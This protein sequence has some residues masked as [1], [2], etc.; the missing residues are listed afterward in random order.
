M[1]QSA[2]LSALMADDVS[3]YN[4]HGNGR[5]SDPPGS[6][7]MNRKKSIRD[8]DLNGRHVLMR[9]DFNV[10][11]DAAG[12]ITD[13][14]R[15]RGSV[16]TIRYVLD[17]GAA[18]ILASHL[19]R[20]K[21]RVTPGLSLAP[22]AKRL[23]QLLGVPVELAPD[24]TGPEVAQ[25][26]RDLR[27][28]Q[29]LLLE[30]LRFHPEEEANDP[31]FARELATLADL[32]VNDAFGTA[33]RAHASTAGIARHLPAVGGF[34]MERE[35][36]ALGQVLRDPSRPL[37]TIIGGAKISTKIGVLEHLLTVTDSYMIGGGMANSLLCAQGKDVGTSLVEEDKLDVARAFLS[38][39]R[40]RG[41]DVHLPTDVVVAERP[42]RGAPT[43]I[44]S[45]DDVPPG[46][47]IVDIGP[48][49]QDDYARVIGEAGTVV[50]N[51]PMGIFEIK[52]FSQGTL[53]IAQAM[54][55]AR[56][57][58][59]VGGGDSVAAVEQM[60]LADR[61]DHVST[62]GGA[63]LEFLE[64]RELPGVAV[65]EDATQEIR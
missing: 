12:A 10:P 43:R 28:G 42:E 54:A 17:H 14:S 21:G 22:V 26:A 31:V 36:E 19:G 27:P 53:R 16:P 29:V 20:P 33:H 37:A 30:N 4:G 62:G 39:A 34:L 64:G 1:C 45:V 51:G 52:E 65:L 48:R 59:I 3:P 40:A 23:E 49:T 47:A 15:I 35:I 13:D 11:L 2:V 9:V 32:Y 63:S 56:A 41:R 46:W 38:E 6:Q 8:V 50:W 61:I 7:H 55:D 18:L 57:E 5:R 60:G 58:T 44:A 24:S 25:L